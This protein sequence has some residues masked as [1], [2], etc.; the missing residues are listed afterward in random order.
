MRSRNRFVTGAIAVALA[1]SGGV[2]AVAG[3]ASA[4]A[5]TGG[6]WVYSPTT[7]SDIEDT[8]PLSDTSSS[9]AAWADSTASPAGAADYAITTSGNS[10]VGQSRNFS[11]T[12]NKGPK[13]GGPGA[14][15]IV[16]YYFSVN[17]T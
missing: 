9:L 2:L 7:P 4:A 13:N 14:N 15:G 11:M 17:G 5:P 8:V 12:F 10:V 1:A 6:C 3:S 16:Y